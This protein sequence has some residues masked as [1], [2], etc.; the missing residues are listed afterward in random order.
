[1]P[2]GTQIVLATFLFVP[3][4]L[5]LVADGERRLRPDRG[6][7]A[8]L[9]SRRQQLTVSAFAAIVAVIVG[10]AIQHEYARGIR[11]QLPGAGFVRARAEDTA[12]YQW[13]AVNVRANCDRLLTAPGLNS[14]HLWSGVPPVS[15]FNTTLWPI[16]LDETQQSRVVAALRQVD[17]MCVVWDPGRLGR[18][19]EGTAFAGRPLMA[20]LRNGFE[21]RSAFGVWEFRVRIGHHPTFQYEGRLDDGAIRLQLPALVDREVDRVTVVNART[22]EVYAD[23]GNGD[24]EIHIATNG[25]MERRGRF[26]LSAP[27]HVVLR[28]QGWSNTVPLLVLMRAGTELVALVPVVFQTSAGG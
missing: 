6:L 3:I 8:P 17:R 16:L 1:M 13:L 24:V 18:L 5:V 11:L 28:G 27:R 20:T 22:E 2:D 26:N 4:A 7:P 19:T 15:T 9:T 23:S 10:S 12:T 25:V 14:L 21:S